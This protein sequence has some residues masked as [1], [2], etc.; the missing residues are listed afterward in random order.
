V[1]AGSEAAAFARSTIPLWQSALGPDLLGVYLIGSLAHS[2]FSAR[3]SDVDM[4]VTTEAGIAE[5]ALARV[6]AEATALSRDW[7]PKLS[8]RVGRFPPLDR[9]DYLD[10]AVPLTER[11]RIWPARPS[12]A[13]VRSYLAGAPLAGWAEQATRFA[14]ADALAPSERKAYLRAL[15][16][17]ARFCFSWMTGRMA[18]NDEAVALLRTSHPAGLNVGL[19]ARA[20]QCRQADA[21]PDPLFADRALLPAQVEACAALARGEDQSSQGGRS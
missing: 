4:A 13:E 10:H 17:P 16:Y 14:R 5:D 8:V 3:Y 6:K 20:L 15:L 9:I 7:G 21:D 11:E 19:L 12:I 18:S 2:G 1:S